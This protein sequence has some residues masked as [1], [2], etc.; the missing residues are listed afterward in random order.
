[1]SRPLTPMDAHTL[2]MLA[3]QED[4]PRAD[5][6]LS[7]LVGHPLALIKAPEAA[8]GYL[9]VVYRDVL[10]PVVGAVD[11]VALL[12]TEPPHRSLRH[13]ILPLLRTFRRGAGYTPVRED[14]SLQGTILGVAWGRSPLRTSENPIQAKFAEFLFWALG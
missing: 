1:V 7:Q 4:L 6:G 8:T 14:A 13:A 5:P 11:P 9:H 10:S 12:L 3:D 2:E